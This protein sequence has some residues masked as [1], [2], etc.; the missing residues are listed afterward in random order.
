MSSNGHEM[1]MYLRCGKGVYTLKVKKAGVLCIQ[2][3]MKNSKPKE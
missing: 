2:H 1:D 3:N